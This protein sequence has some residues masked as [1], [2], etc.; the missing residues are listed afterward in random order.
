M[1][2]A[3]H[4]SQRLSNMELLRIISM[5]M[6]LAVHFDGASLG[7]PQLSGNVDRMNGRRAWQLATESITIIG[8]NCFTL[9]SGY[10]GI[11]RQGQVGSSLLVSMYIL[12]CRHRDSYGHNGSQS[13][14]LRPMA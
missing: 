12:R 3:N 11:K 6:V 1:Q 7:L 10:F 8:V 2:P 14:K 4:A 9:L 5:L 13:D